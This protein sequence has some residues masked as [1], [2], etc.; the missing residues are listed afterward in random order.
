MDRQRLCHRLLIVWT[1][2]FGAICALFLALWG[3]SYSRFDWCGPG[4]ALKRSGQ[5]WHPQSGFIFESAQGA[6][7][8]WFVGKLRDSALRPW[9]AG[10]STE[11]RVIGEEGVSASDGFRAKYYTNGSFRGS[12]PH[13]F[14]ALL[15]GVIGASVWVRSFSLRALLI[16]MTL[17]AILLGIAA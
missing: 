13:W 5:E 12:V 11:L 6:I 14:P 1:I 7:S 4:I 3:R 15:S 16:A 10:S 8:I 17:F 9:H 2:I